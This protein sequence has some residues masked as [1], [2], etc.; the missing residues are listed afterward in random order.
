M[1]VIRRRWDSLH[2][3]PIELKYF[4]QS[5]SHRQF[6]ASAWLMLGTL[7]AGGISWVAITL[8]ARLL[9]PSN[10]G[11]LGALLAVTSLTAIAFRPA[12]FAATQLAAAVG[13]RD[14]ISSIRGLCGFSVAI[15]AGLAAILIVLMAAMR[16]P[17][18]MALQMASSWPILFLAPL[19]AALGCTQ[20][21]QGILAGTNKFPWLAAGSVL[22]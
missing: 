9:E 20:L 12:G 10:F 21:L 3:S 15:G 2:S 6:G 11:L 13:S 4:S 8:S 7:I 5:N 16:V 14:G 18:S 17:L 19:V 22:D 1:G